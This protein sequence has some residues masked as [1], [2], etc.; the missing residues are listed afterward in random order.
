MLR[1]YWFGPDGNLAKDLS[2]EAMRLALEQK[3]GVLWIDLEDPTPEEVELLGEG[4]LRFHPLAI[5]DCLHAQSSPKV[6]DYEE[7]LFV[8][9]HAWERKDD[10]VRL[11]ELDCFLGKNFVVTYH[12]EPRNSIRGVMERLERDPKQLCG[13]GADMLFHAIID[14]MVDRYSVVVDDID[15]RVDVLEDRILGNPDREALRGILALKRDLQDLFRTVRH[16]RDVLHSLSREGHPVIAKKS[17]EFFRDVYDHVV[18]VHDTVELLRDEVAGLRDAYLTMVSNRMNEVM[19]S[20]ALV[21]TIILPL[22]FLTG[23]YGMN[24]EWMPMLHH[25]QGFWFAAGLMLVLGIGMYAWFRRKGW[26]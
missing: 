8:V 14:R 25:E 4:L 24:F 20:L 10:A 16:Q 9:F 18:R 22:T 15:S 19:K 12:V 6:D 13:H 23:I 26:A 17:R 5:E 2:R 7:Y 21:S 11:E 3:K 1:S